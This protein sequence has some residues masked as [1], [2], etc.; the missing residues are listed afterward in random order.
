MSPQLLLVLMVALVTASVTGLLTRRSFIYLPVYW[1]LGVSALLIG[2]VVGRAAGWHLLEVG[3]VELGA[4][5]ILTAI[6]MVGLHMLGLWYNA[7]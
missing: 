3:Q 2:Q 4:G 1:V 6:M 7:A 5:L